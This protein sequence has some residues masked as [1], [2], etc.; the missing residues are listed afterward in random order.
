MLKS[1]SLI[2]GGFGM[3]FKE[4]GSKIMSKNVIKNYELSGEMLELKQKRDSE[5][6]RIMTGDDQRILVLVGPCSAHD[7]ESVLEYTKRLKQVQDRLVDK[8][9]IIPRV[10]TNKPRTNGDG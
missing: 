10:Y 2:I 4:I 5:L 9:F 7:E 6:M 3:T 8:L 1:F